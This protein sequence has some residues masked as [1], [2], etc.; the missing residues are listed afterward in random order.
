MLLLPK[1][2]IS[3]AEAAM[4][5]KALNAALKALRHPKPSQT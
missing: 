4:E 1:H 5:G 3:G 2:E